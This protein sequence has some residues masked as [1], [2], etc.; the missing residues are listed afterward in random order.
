MDL[1]TLFGKTI[2]VRIEDNGAFVSTVRY[3]RF[4]QRSVVWTPKESSDP[5]RGNPR[6]NR[7]LPVS[8]GRRLNSR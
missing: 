2:S 3:G 5:A 8:E 7:S 6:V 4:Y 1:R